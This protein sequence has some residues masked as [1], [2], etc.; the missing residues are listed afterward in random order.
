VVGKL[1]I[2]TAWPSSAT[3]TP[4]N[5]SN[6]RQAPRRR[7]P[8]RA[9]T[10]R[11]ND[12]PIRGRPNAAHPNRSSAAEPLAQMSRSPRRFFSVP[13]T[14]D[15]VDPALDS[16]VPRTRSDARPRN[17]FEPGSVR[18]CRPVMSSREHTFLSCGLNWGIMLNTSI[19]MFAGLATGAGFFLALWEYLDNRRKKVVEAERVVLQSQR[20]DI[21]ANT[22][23]ALTEAADAIVQAA[24]KPAKNAAD[25]E[26]VVSEMQ[27]L[28]RVVRMQG[29]LL[30][31]QLDSEKRTL[32]NWRY[33]S[34]ITSR[35]RGTK[36]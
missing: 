21:S 19:T 22:A 28:A 4:R 34:L 14:L 9:R 10:R 11:D 3:T 24:K 6:R 7:R 16:Q 1:S 31:K 5:S 12:P 29:E 17:R 35:P 15:R 27:I 33:G 32:D 30:A 18:D 26:S 23:V 20:L 2:D 25:L 13:W 36:P 8:P